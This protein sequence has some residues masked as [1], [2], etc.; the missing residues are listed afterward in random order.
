M[1]KLVEA[2]SVTK[3]EILLFERWPLF[4]VPLR[5]TKMLQLKVILCF[6]TK[7]YLIF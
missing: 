5:K 3:S 4:Y 2:Y 1:K 6:V 7:Y